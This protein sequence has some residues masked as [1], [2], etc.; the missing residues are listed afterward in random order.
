MAKVVGIGPNTRQ[1][2]TIYDPTC[3]SGSLLLKAA[4]EGRRGITIYG[5]END[6][7]TW[8]LARMNMFLHGHPTAVLWKGNTLSAPYFKNKDGTL[9]T[10]DFAVAN[11]PFSSKA[12]SSGLIPEKDEFERFKDYGVPPAKN[13]DYAFLPARKQAM[14]VLHGI[15]LELGGKMGEKTYH[16]Y[17]AAESLK[18]EDW[19]PAIMGLLQ[20]LH[21]DP[22]RDAD[23]DAWLTRARTE[24]APYLG[25]SG[26][27]IAHKL[28][29]HQALAA[30]LTCNP[31]SGLSAR[32]IH[33]VKGMEF[34]GVCVVSL[35]NL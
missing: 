21:F 9:Q 33:S 18:P 8:A 35:P 25:N 19:R 24:M 34:P 5:Q 20:S 31:M 13:G 15:V 17:I 4:D 30:I 26:G 11:P 32:T 16:Q 12:W 3:G 28:R 1:D 29:K 10:F 27:S 23:A 7:A 6:L 14:E 22:A 2:Q